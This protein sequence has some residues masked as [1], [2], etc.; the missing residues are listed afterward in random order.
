MNEALDSVNNISEVTFVDN[1]SSP[2]KEKSAGNISLASFREESNNRYDYEASDV[3]KAKHN[4]L[5]NSNQDKK[6]SLQ[7]RIMDNLVTLIRI[8]SW[9]V[10]FVIICSVLLLFQIPIILYYTNKPPDKYFI[11]PEFDCSQK[12]TLVCN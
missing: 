12:D 10:L 9:I 5:S 2:N 3:N 1:P 7:M 11:F 8:R 6:N 4:S